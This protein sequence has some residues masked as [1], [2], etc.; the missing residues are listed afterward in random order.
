[1]I[2]LFGVINVVVPVAIITFL[3][4]YASLAVK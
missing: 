2:K 4:F 3:L 1:M